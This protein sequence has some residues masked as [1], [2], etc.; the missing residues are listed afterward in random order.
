MGTHA[1]RRLGQ[2]YIVLAPDTFVSSALGMDIHF[3]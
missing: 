2:T 1:N 3:F